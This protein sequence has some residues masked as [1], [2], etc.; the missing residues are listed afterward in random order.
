MKTGIIAQSIEP[1]IAASDHAGTISH[2][3]INQLI[4]KPG[5]G[6]DHRYTW[7]LPTL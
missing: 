5:A 3:C 2:E 6:V 7:N 4:G 1:G